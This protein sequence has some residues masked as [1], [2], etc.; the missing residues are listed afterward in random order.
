MR[1]SSI[2]LKKKDIFEHEKLLEKKHTCSVEKKVP[3]SI[4]LDIERIL[5]GVSVNDDEKMK[6][7]SSAL[8]RCLSATKINEMPWFAPILCKLFKLSENVVVFK[9]SS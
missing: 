2:R 3:S 4:N 9:P 6:M 7:Y 5:E 1:A 8:T